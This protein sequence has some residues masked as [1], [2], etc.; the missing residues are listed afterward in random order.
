MEPVCRVLL[1]ILTMINDDEIDVECKVSFLVLME[2]Q[3]ETP[4]INVRVAGFLG[5]SISDGWAQTIL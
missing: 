4:K 5:F 2:L 1:L 3:S